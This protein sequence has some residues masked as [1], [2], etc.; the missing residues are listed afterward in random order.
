V[1]GELSGVVEMA[2]LVLTG[3]GLAALRPREEA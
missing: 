3:I 1:R 2:D